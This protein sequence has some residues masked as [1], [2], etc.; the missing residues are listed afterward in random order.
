MTSVQYRPIGSSVVQMIHGQQPADATE[1]QKR[2][3]HAEK[4][5]LLPYPEHVGQVAVY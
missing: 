5:T 1:V 3:L 4:P 2:V